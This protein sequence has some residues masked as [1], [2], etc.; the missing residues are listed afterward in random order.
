MVNP[1]PAVT[2]IWRFDVLTHAAIHQT[3]PDNFPTRFDTQSA[4]SKT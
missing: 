1:L 4:Y 2:T 3:R